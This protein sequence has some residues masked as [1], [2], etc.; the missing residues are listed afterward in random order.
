MLIGGIQKMTLID[1]P[2]KVAAII[3][4][5]GCNFRCRFCYNTRLVEPKL[6]KE[7]EII[8]EKTIFDFLKT[9]IGKLDA[10]VITGGEP[11][12]QKDLAVFIRKIK[13]MGFLV[14]LDT[15]GTNPD[16]LKKLLAEKLLDYVAMDIK[17]ELNR[18][19]YQKVV[20]EDIDIEKIKGSIKILMNS[21]IDYEFRTTV[22]PGIT[23]ENI[24]NIA[25][26]I[27]GAKKYYLQEFQD[28]DVIDNDCKQKGWLKEDDLN[29]IA[30]EISN[31][32]EECKVR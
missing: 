2:A 18:E 17:N 8:S 29:S 14:K 24:L 7:N 32:V 16:S 1:Y 22:A 9:R 10:I 25:K 27:K 19:D 26:Y 13:K 15:N 30:L 4:T 28:M 21:N 3:F 31:I 20:Q 6:F 5:I 23:K 12:L 11:T